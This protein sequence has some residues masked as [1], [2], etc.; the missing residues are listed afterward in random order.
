MGPKKTAPVSAVDHII[1]AFDGVTEMGGTDGWLVTF[2][3]Q[4]DTNSVIKL[5]EMLSGWKATKHPNIL[6]MIRIQG[7]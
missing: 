4:E 2:Q 7:V 5:I 3:N 6:H 1:K